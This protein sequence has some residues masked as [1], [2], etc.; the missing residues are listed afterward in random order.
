MIC[1]ELNFC[2][3][4]YCMVCTIIK[5]VRCILFSLAEESVILLIDDALL[6]AEPCTI[7]FS[8]LSWF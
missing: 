3:S 7:A 4:V 5:W 1:A 2:G 8:A 6:N